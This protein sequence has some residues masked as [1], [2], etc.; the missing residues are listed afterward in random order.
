MGQS[1]QSHRL[2]SPLKVGFDLTFLG[3]AS[4]G[5][6]RYAVELA[7]ALA[8]R[9]DVILELVVTRDCPREV[10]EAS[11]ARSLRWWTLPVGHARPRVMI[12]SQFALIPLLAVARQWD[13]VHG[14]ANAVPLTFPGTASVITMHDTIWL[15]APEEWGTPEA[16]RAMHRIA[17]PTA[18]RATRVL[19]VS[20]DAARSL[21]GG[22]GL[23]PARID[24]AP[25]GVRLPDHA[26]IE[27]GDADVRRRFGLGAGPVILCVAQLR[28]YKNQEALVHALA[29]MPDAGT[30]LVLVGAPTRYGDCLRVLARELGVAGRVVFAGWLDD[31]ELGDLFRVARVFALTTRREGFGLPVLEAMAYG[32][33][34]VCSDLAVLREVAGDAAIFVDEEDTAGLA[35]ALDRVLRDPELREDFASR[36]RLRAAAASWS[37]TAEATVATYRRAV[38]ASLSGKA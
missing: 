18:R 26:S 1:R 23:P 4:G 7:R 19:T 29:Q 13:V 12:A 14:P 3:Q 9:D 16:V 25:H 36:G 6:G 24:V 20:R 27:A 31:A 8:E 2:P 15:D 10:R 28:A 17:A 32:V 34:V 33:P 5:V 21:E 22:L 11:W 30:Q 37:D 38:C 35:V